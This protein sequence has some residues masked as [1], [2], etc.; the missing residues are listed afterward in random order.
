MATLKVEAPAGSQNILGTAVI[1]APLAK[2]F[3]AYTDP[4][5]FKKWWGRGHEV[6]VYEFNAVTGGTWHIAEVAEDGNEYAFRG[7]IHEVAENERIIQTNEFLGLPERGVVSLEKAEFVAL[8]DNTTE[9]RTTVTV[10]SVEGRD[11]YVA[12]G[13]EGGWRQ[14]VEVLGT[15]VEEV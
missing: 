12:S 10:Q 15:L 11:A 4:E 5:L 1:K 7:T 9:V 14:S 8:D 13:M 3:K 2:V 6:K